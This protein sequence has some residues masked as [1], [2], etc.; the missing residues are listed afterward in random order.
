MDGAIWEWGNG[1]GDSTVPA[2]WKWG[3]SRDGEGVYGEIQSSEICVD[4]CGWVPSGSGNGVNWGLCVYV[5]GASFSFFDED[6]RK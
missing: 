1:N 4:L 3:M 6:G 2:L 5:W